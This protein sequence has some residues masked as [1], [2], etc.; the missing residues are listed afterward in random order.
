MSVSVLFTQCLQ[1]DFV[2]PIGKYEAL[3]NLLHVGYEEARRL[4]GDKP[5]EGPVARVMEWAHRQPA[6]RLHLIHIRDWH[7]PADPSQKTHLEQFGP[8][9]LQGT[10]GA[11]FAFPEPKTG[12]DRATIVSSLSLNDFTSDALVK[13]L[14]PLAGTPVRVG[15][16]GVWT[17]AKV[18]FLAYELRTRYP[19]FEVAVCSALAASSSR[20]QH[21]VALDQMEKLLGVRVFPAVGQFIEFLGDGAES[22]PALTTADQAHPK[23]EFD[24]EVTLTATD[25]QLLRHLFRDSRSARFHRLDGGFSGNAVLA[26]ESVDMYGHEQVPHVV[27]IGQQAAIGR[28]RAAFERVESVLGNNAPRITD[29]ADLGDRGAIKYRYAS[30]GGEFSTTFQKLYMQE[31]PT[32]KL[33]VV[34][35]EVFGEQLGKLYA[36]ASQEKCD[37]IQYY[38]FSPRWAPDVRKQVESLMGG[39]ATGKALRFENGTEFPN[40]CSFYE[41]ELGRLPANRDDT[42]F[43]SYVHGDLNGANIIID[44]HENVW[45]ID[46]FHTHRGHVLKDLIKLENDLLYIY[47]PVEN[48]EDFAQALSFTRHLLKVEDLRQPLPPVEETDLTGPQFIRAY[49]AVSVLRSYYP[50]LIQSDRDPL[51]LLL[52]QLRYAVHTLSFVE[53]NEWQRKWAL[54]TASLCAEQ[55]IERLERVGPLRVDW[56]ENQFTGPGRVG[57]TILPGRKDSGRDLDRDIAMLKKQGVTHIGFLVTEDELRDYGVAGLTQAYRDAGLE[58]QHLPILDQRVCSR[59][60]M[61]EFVGWMDSVVQSGGKLVLHCVGGIGRSGIAAACFLQTKG[62][63][64]YAAIQEVRRIRSPRAIENRLQEQF[65]AGFKRD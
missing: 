29:F 28:E 65:V 4:I 63:N 59:G 49:E 40:V 5:G 45:L 11:R 12:P 7:D 46:F 16:M 52:G 47:T 48:E 3:P 31:L 43:L 17:E 21:F 50:D 36:A 57:L 24:G 37:L 58:F 6:D 9:C 33:R 34:L 32:D 38:G 41:H 27:K 20:S 23:I 19:E 42:S 10:D 61:V 64:A 15:I 26:S 62:L 2:K 35:H 39:P 60:E 55:V 8:H 51:Q 14:A 13:R 54:Y 44:E 53:S 25:I 30:M 22:L 56:L 18:M 1:Q